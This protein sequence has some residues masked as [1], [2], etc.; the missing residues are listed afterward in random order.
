MLSVRRREGDWVE[1]KVKPCT[2]CLANSPFSHSTEREDRKK[3]NG[4]KKKKKKE[5]ESYKNKEDGCKWPRY[6][7]T[8]QGSSSSGERPSASPPLLLHHSTPTDGTKSKTTPILPLCTRNTNLLPQLPQTLIPHQKMAIYSYDFFLSS[9]SPYLHTL[10]AYHTCT[11]S[12][13]PSICC[14]HSIV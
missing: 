3:G 11:P 13:H 14:I 4:R 7:L 10:L 12:I 6:G 1:E 2:Q 5:K 8:F 9:V